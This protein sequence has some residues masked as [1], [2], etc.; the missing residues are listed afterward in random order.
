MNEGLWAH[1]V[2]IPLPRQPR[3]G[4]FAQQAEDPAELSADQLARLRNTLL[5]DDADLRRDVLRALM[6]DSLVPMTVDA[7]AFDGVVT[8]SGTV[9]ADAERVDA[10]LRA[11]FVPGVLGILDE[12]RLISAPGRDEQEADIA[13]EIVA[14]IEETALVDASELSVEAAGH[15]AVVMSGAVRSWTE[16]QRAVAA[17]WSVPGVVSVEDCVTTE[18]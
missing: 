6:L 7:Q 10:M 12:I 16:R 18:D 11:G 17:A 5:R 1:V 2:R 3:D 15:G 8:L 9:N 13:S 14:A 4:G